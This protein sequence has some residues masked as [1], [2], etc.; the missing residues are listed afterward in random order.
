MRQDNKHV[1]HLK[2]E[3][4]D[5]EEIDRRHA[6]EVIAKESLPVLGRGPPGTRDHVFGDGALGDGQAKFE[7]FTVDSG[8]APERIGATH[9]A[10]QAD[11][12]RGD[13]FPT[14]SAGAAFP[15]P[16]ES[17]SRSMPLDDGAGLSQAKPSLPSVP[18]LRK[19]CP[20]GTVYRRQAWAI[21]ATVEDQKLVVQSEILE[22][23]V[24]AGLKPG[25]N[26][27]ECNG[28]PADHAL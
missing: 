14:D 5:A 12:V 21:G 13:G 9:F 17:K 6:A 27:T 8:S 1:E 3:R 24:S 22:E 4:G 25:K 2:G 10:D 18:G 20:K 26:K 28:Q 7:Q 23:Q 15:S 11:R 19:P 16:E